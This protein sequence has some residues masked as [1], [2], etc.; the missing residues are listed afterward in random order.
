MKKAK[1]I[2]ITCPA[3]LNGLYPQCKACREKN[4]PHTETHFD[5]AH[6]HICA[7][8]RVISRSQAEGIT[9]TTANK[10]RALSKKGLTQEAIVKKLNASLATTQNQ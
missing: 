3:V 1:R 5:S 6:N 8:G 10:I 2:C 9:D 4:C 7:C